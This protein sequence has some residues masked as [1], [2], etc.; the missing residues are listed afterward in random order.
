MK[1]DLEKAI[2]NNVPAPQLL[3]SI[4]KGDGLISSSLKVCFK[5]YSECWQLL[6]SEQGRRYIRRHLDALLDYAD[7]ISRVK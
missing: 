6:A 5:D 7:D 3:Y 1:R 4:L 2:E